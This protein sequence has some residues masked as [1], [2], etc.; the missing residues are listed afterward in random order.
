MRLL[1]CT[2]KVDKNDP[3]LGFSHRWIEEFARHYES[4]SVVCLQEGTHTLPAN[5]RVYSLGKERGPVS[6]S[7]YALRFWKLIWRLR[8]EYDAVFVHMNQEYV[9]L[10]ALPWIV[11][12][13]GIYMWRNHYAGSFLTALAV[14]CSHK[15][16][17]TSRHS[18][19]A[20]FKKTVLMPVGIDTAIFKTDAS[21][22]RTPRSILSLGRIAPSKHV[23][24]FIEALHTLSQRQIPFVADIYGEALPQD[25]GY[26]EGLKRQVSEYGLGESVTFRGSVAN[27]LTPA[28]YQSHTIFVNTSRS[29]MYDKTIF[30]AAACGC[31]VFASSQDFSDLAGEQFSFSHGS[32]AELATRLE[33]YLTMS[34]RESHAMSAELRRVAQEHSLRALSERLVAAMNI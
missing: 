20:R 25:V 31:I 3:V 30:E 1:I 7:S 15:V 33:A 4:I 28:V 9:L 5:V 26:L 6:R 32:A 24:V 18:Y 19:T 27:H 12:R 34:E 17:C 21:T 10:G 11:L 16:F 29:G 23:D 13:K 8:K 14:M 22:P 2:Q